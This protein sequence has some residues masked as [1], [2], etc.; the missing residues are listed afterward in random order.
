MTT[1]QPIRMSPI[2]GTHVGETSIMPNPTTPR[3][4]YS[5]LPPPTQPPRM[6]EASGTITPTR[7]SFAA[8]NGK[9]TLPETSTEA[10]SQQE[11]GQD[12]LTSLKRHDSQL[13]TNSQSLQDVDMADSDEGEEGS[14]NDSGDEQSERPSK[15]KKKGQRFFC[16]DYPPCNLSFTR[17]EHLA[18][19]I[20]SV[21]HHIGLLSLTP[22]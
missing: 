22:L 5:H 17:S 11:T 7:D 16:T 20:R 8:A 19:H 12:I 13:S 21:V 14:D 6:P 18:R 9:R 10:E 1:L 4:T 3:A 15:K 2:G